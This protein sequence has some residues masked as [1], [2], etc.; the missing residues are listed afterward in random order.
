[1]ITGENLGVYRASLSR[2]RLLALRGPLCA[3]PRAHPEEALSIDQIFDGKTLFAQR[4]LHALHE[5]AHLVVSAARSDPRRPLDPE[6][7]EGAA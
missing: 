6:V 4:I 3:L 2:G 5:A 7:S 1:M